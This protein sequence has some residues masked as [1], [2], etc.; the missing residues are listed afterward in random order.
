MSG[1]G[2]DFVVVDNRWMRFSDEEL[3]ALARRYSPRRTGVGADGLLA[4]DVPEGGG[5]DFRMRYRNADGTLAAMC[6]NGARC[7]ARF[8]RRAGIA[9]TPG[10]GG[11]TLA[12]DSD[13]GRYS[14]WVPD[15]PGAPVTLHIPE[16]RGFAPVALAEVDEPRSLS[17]IWT[18]TEHAV[19]FVD[20]TDAEDVAGLGARI[21]HDAALAPAG[22]NVDFVQVVDAGGAGRPARVRARTFEKGVEEETHACGTGAVASALAARLAGRLDA[23]R[24]EVQMPGGTLTVGFRLEGPTAE[25]AG[26]ITLEGPARVVFEGTLAVPPG[27][28]GGAR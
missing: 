9:G 20:D 10:Q 16:A 7:L 5:A 17:S 24:V 12:F 23:D 6:G 27:D 2:N 1:A 22:A 14:A 26:A 18:G 21:R 3:A 4:L 25:H 19:L 11:T 15:D 8:A 13:A 28:L